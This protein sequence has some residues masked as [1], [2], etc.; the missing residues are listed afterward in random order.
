MIASRL[1]IGSL[2]RFFGCLGDMDVLGA[3]LWGAI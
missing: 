3:T 1:L 2:A